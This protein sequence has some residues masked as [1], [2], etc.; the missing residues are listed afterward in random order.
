MA[1]TAMSKG[2]QVSITD[3]LEVEKQCYS[4]VVDTKDRIE[5]LAAFV[6]KRIPIYQG[7]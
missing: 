4:K 7:M 5:G 6:T 2:L 3:G 1:K